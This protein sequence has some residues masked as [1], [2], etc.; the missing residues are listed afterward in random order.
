MPITG[1]I[2]ARYAA[3]RAASSMS[4]FPSDKRFPAV[5]T[6]IYAGHSNETNAASPTAC[7]L[8]QLLSSV[9]FVIR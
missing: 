8:S 2:A 5:A 4:T 7:F 9:V 1:E 6:S 3:P